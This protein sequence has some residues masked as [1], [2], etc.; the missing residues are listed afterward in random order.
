MIVLH[1]LFYVWI[2]TDSNLLVS[3][4][5]LYSAG[6]FSGIKVGCLIL[7]FFLLKPKLFTAKEMLGKSVLKSRCMYKIMAGYPP[8]A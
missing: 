2:F 8:T 1:F 4:F 7:E 6:S 3:A 5:F